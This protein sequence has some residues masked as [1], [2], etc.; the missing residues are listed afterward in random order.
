V[1]L[2]NS[3]A[4]GSAASASLLMPCSEI[5]A[6]T[7]GVID[8]PDHSV[9]ANVCVLL[10]NVRPAMGRDRQAAVADDDPGL[11]VHEMVWWAL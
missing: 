3:S 7:L 4:S 10:G 5:G 9:R 2:I 11:D 6:R 8:D 1:F